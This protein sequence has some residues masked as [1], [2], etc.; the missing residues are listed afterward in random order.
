[1]LCRTVFDVVNKAA[2]DTMAITWTVTLAA[3]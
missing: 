2:D 1:M 3:A